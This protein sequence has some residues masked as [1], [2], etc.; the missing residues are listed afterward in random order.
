[1]PYSDQPTVTASGVEVP[2]LGF[3]TWQLEADDAR[4]L[5]GDHLP[6]LVRS[7]AEVPASH[8]ATPEATAHLREGLQVV[9]SEIERLTTDIARERLRAL[10]TEGRFLESRYGGKKE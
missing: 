1:M 7:Y 10:E 9:G 6:R 8:R 4:R 5:I 2:L 3:G